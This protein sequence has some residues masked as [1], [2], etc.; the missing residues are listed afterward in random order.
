M[1]FGATVTRGS[2]DPDDPVRGEVVKAGDAVPVAAGAGEA[3]SARAAGTARATRK[4]VRRM[5]G[6]YAR[7]VRLRCGRQ[8]SSLRS[9]A[10]VRA[11]PLTPSAFSNRP[12]VSLVR[13]AFWKPV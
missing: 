5:P 9:V 8:A 12:M 7:F 10:G 3:A 2:D 11:V 1:S 13:A 4:A 6:P